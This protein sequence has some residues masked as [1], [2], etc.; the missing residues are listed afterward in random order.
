RW[1]PGQALLQG[2][3]GVG[4]PQSV[5]LEDAGPVEIDSD[6]LDNL[7]VIGGGMQLKLAGEA[8]DFGVE[9]MGSAAFRSDLKAFAAGGGGAVIAVDVDVLAFDLF[10]GPFVS[11]LFGDRVR[12][13]AAAGPLAEFI[14]YSQSGDSAGV[15]QDGDGFGAGYYARGGLEFLLPSGTLV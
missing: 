15:N 4:Y 6:A 5:E 2:F 14:E 1:D 13:Y 9:L 3:I 10:G 11:K 12:A 8:V 7:P